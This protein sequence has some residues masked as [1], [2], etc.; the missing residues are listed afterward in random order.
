ME[1]RTCKNFVLFRF[2]MAAA[3]LV[4]LQLRPWTVLVK[5]GFFEYLYLPSKRELYFDFSVPH[6]VCECHEILDQLI[7]YNVQR[8]RD[9]FLRIFL[10]PPVSKWPP[11][12]GS[13]L[14]ITGIER[15]FLFTELDLTSGVQV[16]L[17]WTVFVYPFI[18][19]VLL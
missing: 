1:R 7:W 16:H 10:Y 2:K 12:S 9:V 13:F 18:L 6:F 11:F 3:S 5:F 17:P 15:G 14:T 19:S 4:F 8:R